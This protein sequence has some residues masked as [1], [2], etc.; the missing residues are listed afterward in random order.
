MLLSMHLFP[1]MCDFF[2]TKIQE[3]NYKLVTR[4]YHTPHALHICYPD[5]SELC[6]RWRGDRGMLLHVFWSFP[7]L[8]P[9]WSTIR[10]TIQQ[11]TEY[12]ILNDPAFF[13]LL[14][15][16]D[17]PAN[18]YKQSIVRHLLNAAKACIPLC[19]KQQTPPMVTQWL[20][21]VEDISKMEFSPQS[22]NRKSIIRLGRYG[23]N[24][25]PRRELP[26]ALPN[27]AY[28]L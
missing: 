28:T 10:T 15:V 3:T 20:R 6:W 25:S 13:F 12:T 19:W 23:N 17:I 18:L 21:R 7:R 14:H 5:T 26:L 24:S 2:C 16:S 22:A 8:S 4:W 1:S 9:F 11:F 27:R